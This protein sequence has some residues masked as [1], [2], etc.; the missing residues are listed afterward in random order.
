MFLKPHS[1]EW[2]HLADLPLAEW[3]QLCGSLSPGLAES[4]AFPGTTEAMLGGEDQDFL[5]HCPS[6]TWAAMYITCGRG[7]QE[8]E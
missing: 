6:T 1:G 5:P 2:F 8:A 7:R 3:V 4:P